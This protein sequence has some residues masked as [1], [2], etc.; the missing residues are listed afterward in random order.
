MKIYVAY[1]NSR[2]H[3]VAAT[4]IIR[5]RAEAAKHFNARAHDVTVVLAPNGVPMISC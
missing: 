2:R 1:Y 5:A 3:E 4:N